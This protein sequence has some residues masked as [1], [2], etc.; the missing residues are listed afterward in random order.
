MPDKDGRLNI[1]IYFF[2]NNEQK[3]GKTPEIMVKFYSL[4]SNLNRG[5]IS[6]YYLTKQ[7]FLLLKFSLDIEG[8]C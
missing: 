8:Q 5:L 6:N 3:S 2:I 1:R 4:Y 7:I